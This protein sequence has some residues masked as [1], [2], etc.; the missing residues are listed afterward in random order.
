MR[1]VC[2]MTNAS[3][4][5]LEYVLIAFHGNSGFTNARWCYIYTHIACLFHLQYIVLNVTRYETAVHK[6]ILRE[7]TTL[8][9]AV[10]MKERERTMSLSWDCSELNDLL[11]LELQYFVDRNLFFPILE[12]SQQSILMG[13]GCYS[14]AHPPTWRTCVCLCVW[15]ITFDPYGMEGPTSSNA[16]TRIA[17][18][19]IWP[20]KPNQYVKVRGGQTYSLLEI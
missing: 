14:H 1:L 20:R 10:I 6:C 8:A 5:R 19:I 15:V 11:L 9:K 16:A 3:D 2:W 4:T 18:R 7:V 17:H 12:A 13:W